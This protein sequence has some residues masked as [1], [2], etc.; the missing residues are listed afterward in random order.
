M[1]KVRG[2]LK[3]LMRKQLPSSL[4]LVAYEGIKLV[5]PREWMGRATGDLGRY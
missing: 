5:G 2:R 1:A 3:Y 4:L